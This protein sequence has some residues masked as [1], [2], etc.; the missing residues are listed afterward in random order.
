MQCLAV[1]ALCN[2]VFVVVVVAAAVVVV[3]FVV[4]VV[5]VTCDSKLEDNDLS[6][7]VPEDIGNLLELTQLYVVEVGAKRQHLS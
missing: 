3:V 5:V 7:S 2:F 4:V 6:G 1:R